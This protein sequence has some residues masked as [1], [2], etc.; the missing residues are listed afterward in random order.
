MDWTEA[1]AR[2]ATRER[3]IIRRQRLT[4]EHQALARDDSQVAA[5]AHSPERGRWLG[6]GHWLWRRL[7]GPA[8]PARA[9][10][11]LRVMAAR[12]A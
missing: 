1:E 8:A 4:R 12:V 9:G 11:P 7:P 6:L 2:L 3:E 5:V 10:D